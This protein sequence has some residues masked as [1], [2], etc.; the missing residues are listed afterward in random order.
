MN[1]FS[2]LPKIKPEQKYVRFPFYMNG[3]PIP[4]D[5]ASCAMTLRFAKSMRFKN[6]EINSNRNLVFS[7]ILKNESDYFGKEFASLE[8]IHSKKVFCINEISKLHKKTGD[9]I[10]TKNKKIIPGITVADC[11]P[12]FFCNFKENIFGIVHSG[13]KGTGIIEVAIKKACK[14]Y[15]ANVKD[16]CV[17]T[18]PHIKNCCYIV[19][20]ER[21]LYFY[22]NFGKDC[23]KPLESQGKI[24]CGGRNFEWQ[25][26]NGKLFRLSLL[27]E[28]C[29]F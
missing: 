22:K 21:A 5:F 3:Q 8:L 1:E 9:G 4:L 13:W 18:G 12:I 16:F 28:I 6:N 24:F 15:N 11:M 25:N 2:L 17:V 7:E 19:N 23:V 20:E 14:K 26:G 29:L 27:D 10:I